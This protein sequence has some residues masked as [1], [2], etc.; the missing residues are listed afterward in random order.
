MSAKQE[1]TE[2]KRHDFYNFKPNYSALFY[3]LP[4]F[5]GPEIGIQEYKTFPYEEDRENYHDLKLFI[6]Q[7]SKF[8]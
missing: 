4:A 1:F 7:H 2:I 3:E 5:N 8:L 6:N